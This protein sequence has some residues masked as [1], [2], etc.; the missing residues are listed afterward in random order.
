MA[1][2]LEY[3]MEKSLISINCTRGSDGK[4]NRLYDG[5]CGKEVG[6]YKIGNSVFSLY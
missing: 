5:S 6:V 1:R 3:I 4:E 2:R